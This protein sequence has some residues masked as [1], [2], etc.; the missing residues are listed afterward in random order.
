MDLKEYD[1]A[2]QFFELALHID[3]RRVDLQINRGI[4]LYEMGLLDESVEA[5]RL[6]IKQNPRLS[7]AH[8]GL[9]DAYRDQGRVEEAGRHYGEVLKLDPE[10]VAAMG[11]FATYLY[12]KGDSEEAVG[13]WEKSLIIKETPEARFNLGMAYRDVGQN[14][15][16]KKHLRA[17]L[18]SSDQSNKKEVFLALKWLKEN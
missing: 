6:A 14:Q 5:F 9:A 3:P 2:L 1:E 16:A 10:D 8:L 11:N 12:L 15:Q 17:F 13:Y 18:E 7:K 4:S